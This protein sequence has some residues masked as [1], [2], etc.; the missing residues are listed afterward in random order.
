MRA[1]VNLRVEILDGDDAG[2]IFEDM[3]RVI[4][5]E[6]NNYDIF[7]DR[8]IPHKISV[9]FVTPDQL[10]G[11]RKNN[12]TID[13]YNRIKTIID[14][15]EVDDDEHELLEKIADIIDGETEDEDS[16]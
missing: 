8:I 16:N 14:N 5:L 2:Y 3:N 13:V 7:S 15:W 9:S 1:K 12:D 11:R 10:R 6:D 4:E